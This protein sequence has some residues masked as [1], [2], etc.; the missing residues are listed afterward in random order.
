M[1]AEITG[2]TLFYTYPV[3]NGWQ[4]S[5]QRKDEPGWSITMI[6]EEQARIVLDL[7]KNSGHPD[8]PWELK[9]PPLSKK[10]LMPE[11]DAEFFIS[12]LRKRLGVKHSIEDDL[13]NAIEA[14]R[15]LTASL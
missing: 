7:L 15:K 10:D 2:F 5:V 1:T 11:S 3:K 14:R 4:M 12:E 6:P 8:G 13:R 9:V